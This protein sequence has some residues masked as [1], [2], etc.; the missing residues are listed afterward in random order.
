VSA[1][2]RAERDESLG[3]MRILGI[4]LAAVL[5]TGFFAYLRFP[6]D[7]LADSL[8]A[9]LERDAG[10]RLQIGRLAASPQLAG[11]GL[12]AESVQLVRADGTRI[13]IDQLRVRPAWS[14]SWLALR[15]ALH[16]DVEAPLGRLVGTAVL[17]APFRFQ[18]R[19]EDLNLAD[20]A[21]LGVD[22]AGAS[23]EGRA[24]LDVDVALEPEGPKGPL[25]ISAREGV[26]AHPD[27]PMA[28]PY[29]TLEG[30]LVFGGE[31][32][33]SI[34]GLELKSPLGHGRLSGTIGRAPDPMQ[35]P[36]ALEAAL[37]VAEAI[38]GS[39][40]GQG[41]RVGRDGKI[42]MRVTGTASSPIVR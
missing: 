16:L 5:L 34:S 36:L 8:T 24:H 35:A 6:Y 17:R 27:L 32:F 42:Q 22:I 31:N 7:R 40:S 3:A 13:Q 33:L 10:V 14:L 41:V 18:G 20:L 19:L 30:D 12:V 1:A 38:R 29:E 23:L 37:E 26:L 25:H 4:A 15:P 9:R 2:A 21:P 28:I 39:L 11:P